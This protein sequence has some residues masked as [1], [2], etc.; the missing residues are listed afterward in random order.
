MSREEEGEGLTKYLAM[1]VGNVVGG[2]ELS[3]QF[4]TT[5]SMVSC[6]S[7]ITL[8]SVGWYEDNATPRQ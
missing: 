2:S 1:S 3:S 6:L 5:L 8:S 7:S 4:D